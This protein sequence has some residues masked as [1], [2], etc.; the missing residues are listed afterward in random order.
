MNEVYAYWTSFDDVAV[1]NKMHI[2]CLADLRAD[3]PG[4]FEYSLYQ[5]ERPAT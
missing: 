1:A 2:E 4:G 3:S 5:G